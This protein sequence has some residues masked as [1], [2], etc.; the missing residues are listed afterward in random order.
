VATEITFKDPHK[1][2]TVTLK[3]VSTSRLDVV[4]HQRPATFGFRWRCGL[5]LTVPV[6]PAA[7]L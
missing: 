2:Q 5:M 7:V 4:E 3:R 6:P 1:R